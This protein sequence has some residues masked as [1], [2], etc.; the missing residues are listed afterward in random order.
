MFVRVQAEY[1]DDVDVPGISPESIVDSPSVRKRIN[2][3]AQGTY[4]SA[5]PVPRVEYL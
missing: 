3:F 2:D 4:L 5:R 1:G